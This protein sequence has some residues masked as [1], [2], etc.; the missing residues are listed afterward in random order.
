[1][2][3]DFEHVKTAFLDM[4]AAQQLGLE[5]NSLA[6][7]HAE[8]VQ[9]YRDE[10]AEHNGYFRAGVIGTL[11]DFAS[12]SA[13]STL[14]PVGWIA[15]T[16][17]LSVD[18]LAPAKG[19]RLVARGHVVKHDQTSTSATVDVCVI[20]GAGENLCATA[21][22]TLHRVNLAET[23]RLPVEINRGEQR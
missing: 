1:M 14:L 21:C 22:V 13:A 7:G 2:K 9:Q 17:H 6:A 4:P 12:G 10:L 5:F 16:V 18:I 20:D 3:P 15:S 19:E 11:A 8:I 23:A